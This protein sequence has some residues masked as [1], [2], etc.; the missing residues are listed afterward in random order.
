MHLKHAIKAAPDESKQ[1]KRTIHYRYQSNKQAA[2][3]VVDKITFTRHDQID[4]VTNQSIGFTK[5]VSTEGTTTFAKQTSP[6]IKGYTADQLTVPAV[7]NI[8]QDSADITATVTYTG[9]AQKATVTYQRSDNQA[10]IQA[11]QLTGVSGQISDYRTDATLAALADKGYTVADNPYPSDGLVFDDDV[12]VDQNV[13]VLLNYNPYYNRVYFKSVPSEMDFGQHTL[14]STTE[15]YQPTVNQALSIQDERALGSKWTLKAALVQ[16]FTGD[17]QK[18]PLEGDLTYQ[19][20]N[21]LPTMI[22]AQST[23]IATTTTTSHDPVDISGQ[24]QNQLGPQLVVP[25]GGALIDQYAAQVEWT[26]EDGVATE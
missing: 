12:A 16:P 23:I 26:L 1:V 13:T 24:W 5:W 6:V 3:D 21:Q 11:D 22:T 17:T 4:Q 7:E 8:T 20:A 15:S 25:V 19:R 10:V 9:Q 18:A 14:A 2:P